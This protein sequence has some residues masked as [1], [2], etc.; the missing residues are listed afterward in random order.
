MRNLLNLPFQCKMAQ[1]MEHFFILL[2][3]IFQEKI[4]GFEHKTAIYFCISQNF[5]QKTLSF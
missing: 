1:F 5:T 3:F 2:A 4:R